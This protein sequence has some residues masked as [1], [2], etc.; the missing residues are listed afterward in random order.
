[1]AIFVLLLFLYLTD[2]CS[3]EVEV[4]VPLEADIVSEEE[5]DKD[6]GDD[7]VSQPQHGEVGGVQ[8]ILKE[9]LIDCL[10]K[11][12]PRTLMEKC[13]LIQHFNTG[14]KKLYNSFTCGNTSLIGASKLLATV[15][16]TSVPKT[17]KMS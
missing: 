17:Q 6:S 5:G 12:D 13:H 11:L 3:V 10:V 16:I 1:M 2:E 7:N 4:A 8:A 15:T 9:I 14:E